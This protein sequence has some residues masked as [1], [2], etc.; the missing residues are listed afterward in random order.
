VCQLVSLSAAGNVAMFSVMLGAAAAGVAA[1][2]VA[3]AAAAD[4]GTRAG[5]R[6][7]LCNLQCSFVWC[8]RLLLLEW[9]LSQWRQQRLQTWAHEQVRSFSYNTCTLYPCDAG[10]AAESGMAAAAA[11]LGT[12]AGERLAFCD[13]HWSN[14]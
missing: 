5:E 6:L 10:A 11:D 9:L 7:S 1:E 8:S 3:A 13:M 14:M 4:L 2:S 12:R